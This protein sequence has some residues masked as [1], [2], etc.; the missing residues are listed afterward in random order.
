[1]R[2]ESPLGYKDM[3][4]IWLTDTY[5]STWQMLDLSLANAFII[6]VKA[7]KRSNCL[8][9]CERIRPGREGFVPVS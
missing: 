5:A 8:W 1:M 7:H 9:A 3:I 6:C 4:H 2:S